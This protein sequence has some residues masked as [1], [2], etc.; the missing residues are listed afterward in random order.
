MSAELSCTVQPRQIQSED[1]LA[2]KTV[3]DIQLSPDGARMAYVLSEIDAEKDA[4]R[5]SIW[6]GRSDGGEPERFTR[7]PGH[8]SAPRWSPDGSR[9]AFLSD[10]EGE[11]AQLYVMP[12]DGGEGRRLTSLES[13]AGPA[14]W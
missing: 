1:L 5:T 14:A 7:G 12:V 13:G 3:S 2:I 11:N 9:L 4:Y 6:V 8:D 10:R